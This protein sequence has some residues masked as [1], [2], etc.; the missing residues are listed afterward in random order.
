MLTTRTLIDYITGIYCPKC[1]SPR[2]SGPE[3]W[4]DESVYVHCRDCGH[5]WNAAPTQPE[6]RHE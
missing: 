5:N 1:Q 4:T 6:D 2:I 3:W